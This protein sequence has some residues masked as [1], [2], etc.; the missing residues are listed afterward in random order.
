MFAKLA[1]IEHVGVVRIHSRV[2]VVAPDAIDGAR[3]QAL[4]QFSPWY[5]AVHIN[6]PEELTDAAVA[7]LKRLTTRGIA[8]GSQTVLLK[9]I[10]D[11]AT[12]LESLLRRLVKLQVRPYYLH[13]PDLAPGTSHFRVSIE[14]GQALMRVLRCRL[15]GLCLPTYVMDLPGGFGKVPID[16]GHVGTLTPS[17]LRQVADHQGVLHDLPE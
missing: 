7:S 9:G 13:H 10:N 3:L 14:A 12:V 6:H 1:S 17:R 5:V 15:S 16:A 2:P 8:L 11:D 4:M